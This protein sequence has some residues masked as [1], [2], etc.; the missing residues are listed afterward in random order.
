MN[1]IN[2]NCLSHL[3]LTSLIFEDHQFLFVSSVQD[4]SNVALIVLA[5]SLTE[6]LH[7]SHRYDGSRISSP[8]N[9]QL[10]SPHLT[11]PHFEATPQGQYLKAVTLVRWMN[12]ETSSKTR[13]I[14]LFGPRSRT[15][16]TISTFRKRQKYQSS[17]FTHK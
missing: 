17:T 14:N 9:D 8:F 2:L 15:I 11:S 1:I 6:G 4:E 5:T 7:A 10:I 13:G 16:Q 3:S 12:Y